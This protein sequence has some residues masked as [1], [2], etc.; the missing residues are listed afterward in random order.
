MGRLLIFFMSSQLYLAIRE[1]SL[2]VAV[3]RQGRSIELQKERT[4]GLQTKTN[5]DPIE[6]NG[7]FQENKITKAS[8]PLGIELAV[9]QEDMGQ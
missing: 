5:R 8:D 4:F 6:N 1:E 3:S 2:E 7:F 9:K